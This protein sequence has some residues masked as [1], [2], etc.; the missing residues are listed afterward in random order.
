[1]MISVEIS[2]YPLSDK[3]NDIIRAFIDKL[4]ANQHINL[5]VGAMSTLIT[6]EHT[7][8]MKLLS[9]EIAQLFEQFPAV[10]QFKISNACPIR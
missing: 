10:F 2:L 5:E 9:E 1:M 7:L 6:G 3:A 4:A 8:V